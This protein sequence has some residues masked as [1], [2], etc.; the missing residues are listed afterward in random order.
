MRLAIIG[1]T[2]QLGR[3]LLGAAKG[4]GVAAIAYGRDA[5]DLSEAPSV[6]ESFVAA[7]PQNIDCLVIAA[8]YTNVDGAE[9]AADL[10][11]TVNAAAPAAIARA[12]KK[13]GLPLVHISTDYVFD[14]AATTPYAESANTAPLNVYGETK[15]AGERAIIE[16]GAR[17]IILRTSWVFD[18]GGNNFLTAM[19]RLAKTHD[20]LSIVDDQWGRPTY[21]P[22]LARAVFLAA[23]SLCGA[24]QADAQIYHVTGGGEMTNWHGFAGYIFK[25]VENSPQIK[26]ISTKQYG[27]KAKRPKFSGLDNSAFGKRFDYV[28]P[29]WQSG[30]DAALS[31][32]KEAL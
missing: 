21:A 16:S 32:R 8:A 4:N 7:L 1:K 2:G 6:I 11:M 30:V 14:G 5:C 17:S 22:H 19:L 9:D 26:P 18:A 15:L 28:L 12:C 20:R 23:K 10:A 29:H 13:R 24:G 3:A 31:Q 27:A 25:A